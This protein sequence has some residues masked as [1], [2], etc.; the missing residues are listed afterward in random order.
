MNGIHLIC[1]SLTE[2]SKREVA[3]LADGTKTVT[4]R[5]RGD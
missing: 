2:E 4:V 3:T 5:L 1:L